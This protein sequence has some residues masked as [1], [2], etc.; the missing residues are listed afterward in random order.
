[1]I[2]AGPKLLTICDSNIVKERDLSSNFYFS[3]QDVNKNKREDVC[4]ENLKNLSP[5]VVVEKFEGKFQDSIDKLKTFNIV[6]ITEMLNKKIINTIETLC[7]ENKIGFI[8]TCALGL[9]GFAFIDFNDFIIFDETGEENKKYKVKSI[10]KDTSGIVVVDEYENFSLKSGDYVI[11]KEVIGMNEVDE[12]PPRPIKII[13][14]N[15][16]TIEDTTKFG[17]YISGGVIE[18]VKVPKPVEFKDFKESIQ[19][20]NLINKYFVTENKDR[21]KELH[22]IFISLIDYFTNKGNLPEHFDEK[23]FDDLIKIINDNINVYK[24]KNWV[25]KELNLN[26]IKKICTF[27]KCQIAPITSFL[28]GVVSQEIIK[29]TGKFVPIDQWFHFEFNDVI[30]DSVFQQREFSS[31]VKSRY[32]DQIVIFGEEFQ[33][34]LSDLNVLIVGSGK[35]GFELIKNCALIGLST[36]SGKTIVTDYDFIDNLVLNRTFFVDKKNLERRKS[37]VICE[38]AM[39]INK[40]CKYKDLQNRFDISNEDFFDE[41]LWKDID[42]VFSTLKNKKSK[43]IFDYVTNYCMK[44]LY[45]ISADDL[46][47]AHF[48][49][50]IPNVTDSYDESFNKSHQITIKYFPN[51]YEHCIQWAR[52]LFNCHFHQNLKLLHQY[53]QTPDKIFEHFKSEHIHNHIEKVVSTFT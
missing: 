31:D 40:D 48:K 51:S 16:F 42:Y 22:L 39:K 9:S 29:Y 47:N 30:P 19:N 12:S 24:N 21:E 38:T 2:F 18:Q 32:G 25:I 49:Y 17:D 52:E 50:I 3:E 34:K 4:Y 11:F 33:K 35:Y 27:S 53:I 13:Q 46:T 28:G 26:L 20:P 43:K 14:K 37:K 8:F 6:I 5:T 36:N 44:I 45:D 23:A 1:V 41:G 15:T 7:R 10:S